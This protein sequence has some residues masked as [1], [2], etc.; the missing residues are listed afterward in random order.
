MSQIFYVSAYASLGA[1]DNA[2]TSAGGMLYIDTNVTLTANTT[3]SAASVKFS[4]GIITRGTYTL[5]F[6]GFVI[7]PYAAIFDKSSATSGAVSMLLNP[8][9]EEIWF[10]P[11][12]DAGT[13]D[14]SYCMADACKAASR[15]SGRQGI[16]YFADKTTMKKTFASN[17][18][19]SGFSG[20]AIRGR[21]PTTTNVYFVGTGF[22]AFDVGAD[23]QYAINVQGGSPTVGPAHGSFYAIGSGGT[24]TNLSLWRINNAAFSAIKWNPVNGFLGWITLD[25]TVGGFTE[26]F[27]C[28]NSWLVNTKNCVRARRSAG[29]TEDS[30]RGLII[31][32]G[33]SQNLTDV[34]GSRVINALFSNALSCNVYDAK[35]CS[36]NWADGTCV[37]YSNAGTVPIRISVD[38]TYESSAVF[39]IG[40]GATANTISGVMNGISF[41]PTYT[42][43][44]NKFGSFSS[45]GLTINGG[46]YGGSAI[47]NTQTLTGDDPVMSLTGAAVSGVHNAEYNMKSPAGTVVTRWFASVF[48]GAADSIHR[49][50]TG[51]RHVWQIDT[52]EYASIETTGVFGLSNQTNGA[53]A[54]AGTLTNAP[55]TGDP[56]F[57]VPIKINGTTRYFPA[58]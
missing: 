17:P 7:A 34:A 19:N 18:N 57:W 3:L 40:D 50:A 56:A 35:D 4:G 2:A 52:T 1:A 26:Q 5:S 47:G 16:V 53:A 31:G 27:Y 32:S 9:I 41:N 25:N 42:M 23:G 13:T 29:S 49:A 22:D 12:C 8:E 11:T 24:A 48:G 39:A 21:G 55:V 51:W 58:W 37:L 14:D 54:R 33:V 6:S 30:F 20:P 43:A 28:D 45:L 15:S 44:T 46:V 38:K 36:T 10:A